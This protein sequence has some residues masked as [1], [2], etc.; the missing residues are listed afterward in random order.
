MVYP[1]LYIN[2]ISSG[3]IIYELWR[4]FN[5]YTAVTPEELQTYE[6]AVAL[7]II[8]DYH[9]E[10]LLVFGILIS[11]HC[12]R[13]FVLLKVSRTFGPLGSILMIMLNQVMVFLLLDLG[14]VIIFWGAGMIMFYNLDEFSTGTKAMITLM[15]A[16]LGNFDFKM[17]EQTDGNST[18]YG[19][20]FLTTYLIVSC[21]TLLNFLI[22]IL[23]N[24]YDSLRS[25]SNGLYMKDIILIRQVMQD[26]IYY[27][28][29]VVASPP[30]NLFVLPFIPFILK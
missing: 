12:I 18:M 7:R 9:S 22:A 25:I 30:F 15:S 20:I 6:E 17:F 21:V 16:S 11:I 5:V 29:L 14:I 28:A 23:T 10:F 2:A 3:L 19:Y 26:H 8:E 13:V 4:Y 24:V 1:E 27:S